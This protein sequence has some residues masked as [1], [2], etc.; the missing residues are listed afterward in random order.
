MT[1]E[2][3]E[4]LSQ[5]FKERDEAKE[6]LSNYFSLFLHEIKMVDNKVVMDKPATKWFNLEEEEILNGL[7]KER[8]NSEQQL[9]DFI[10]QMQ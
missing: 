1:P 8:D 7:R 5:L 6:K 9:I 2:Q 3:V 4:K 10:K